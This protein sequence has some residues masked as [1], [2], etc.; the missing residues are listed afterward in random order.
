M[1]KSDQV[2]IKLEFDRIVRRLAPLQEKGILTA[3]E[4]MREIGRLRM[5]IYNM[6]I[7]EIKK[8]D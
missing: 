1:T 6:G 3:D 2:Y 4:C 5:F 7:T 8:G